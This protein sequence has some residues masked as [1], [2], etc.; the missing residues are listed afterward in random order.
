[1]V[2]QARAAPNP[3]FP[4]ADCAGRAAG[5]GMF[6]DQPQVTRRPLGN[7]AASVRGRSI[8]AREAVLV[9]VRTLVKL[10]AEFYAESNHTEPDLTTRRPN[11]D[12][13]KKVA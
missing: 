8:D 13:A 5:C 4:P 10:M 6:A 11:H 12:T 2:C 7:V 1:M 3:G 9:D